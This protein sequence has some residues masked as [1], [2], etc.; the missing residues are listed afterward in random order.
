M[1]GDVDPKFPDDHGDDGEMDGHAS[2][3]V[4]YLAAIA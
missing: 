2:T 1:A 4:R 3:K